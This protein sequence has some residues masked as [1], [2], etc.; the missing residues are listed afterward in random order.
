MATRKMTFTLPEDLASRFL[1]AVPSR[2]RSRYV[3]EA[4]AAKLQEREARLIRA[5]EAANSAPDVRVI[6]E[7]WDALPEEIAE[8]WNDAPAR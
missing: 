1:R 2:D 8:P 3:T 4:I 7:E 6:E 5:C